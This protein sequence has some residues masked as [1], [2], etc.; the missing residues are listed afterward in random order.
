[1]PITLSKIAA[2]TADVTLQVGDDVVTITY[3]PNRLTEKLYVEVMDLADE[4]KN[5]DIP[6]NSKR[7]NEVLVMLVKSWDILNEDGSMFPITVESLPDI[8][9]S[10]RFEIYGAIFADMRPNAQE[11]TTNKQ[12]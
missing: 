3:Y 1:M 10:F 11:P 7:L 5:K 4:E 9:L 12:H 2:N 8:P 6:E